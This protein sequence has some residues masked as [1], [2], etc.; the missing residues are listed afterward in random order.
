VV[1]E[2]I[3]NHN[4]GNIG[5]ATNQYVEKRNIL[6]VLEQ[7]SISGRVIYVDSFGN[8]IT[9]IKREEIERKSINNKFKIQYGRSDFVDKI[10]TN[11]ADVPMGY[12]LGRF[13]TIGYLEVSIHCGNASQLLGLDIGSP[14]KIWIE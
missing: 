12:T 4:I 2:I 14:V 10:V 7:S 1:K 13:N 8:V 5:K 3:F 6:P 9:N 11:Y